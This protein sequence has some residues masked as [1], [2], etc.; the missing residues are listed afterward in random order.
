MKQSFDY[1]EKC[2]NQAVFCTLAMMSYNPSIGRVLEKGGVN[3]F[4]DIATEQFATINN[5]QTRQD[6]D[7]WHEQFAV[8]IQNQI[9]TALRHPSSYGEAQKPINVFL[10]VYVDW[11]GLPRIETVERLRPHLH[12]P[13]DSVMMKFT[14]QNFFDYYQKHGLKVVNLAKIDRDLY[15][16]WQ[17]CFREI[18][19]RK[20]LL[21]DIFWA[22]RRFKF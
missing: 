20:P 1:L 14:K 12:V 22:K 16:R 10:K 13:L 4:I 21:M 9:K 8:K 15:N 18:F 19:P 6:F 11:S 5:I 3:K 2:E 7:L 17:K